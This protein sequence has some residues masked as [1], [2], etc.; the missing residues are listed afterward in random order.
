[1]DQGKTETTNNIN[2]IRNMFAIMHPIDIQNK[3]TPE[4][5]TMTAPNAETPRDVNYHISFLDTCIFFP[6]C[7]NYSLSL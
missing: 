2:I 4:M 6:F 3:I 5:T 1:M 7:G